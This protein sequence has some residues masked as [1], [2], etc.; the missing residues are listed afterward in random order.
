MRGACQEILTIGALSA[1]CWRE[2]R[3]N[4]SLYIASLTAYVMMHNRRQN[5]K[6]EHACTASSPVSSHSPLTR[7]DPEPRVI[8][9]LVMMAQLT[10]VDT[11]GML[12]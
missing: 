1:F 3:C 2:Q 11:Q 8:G 4:L 10:T 5:D 9:L 12:C 6:N 7:D